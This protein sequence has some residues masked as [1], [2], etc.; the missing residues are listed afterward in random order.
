MQGNGLGLQ[1]WENQSADYKSYMPGTILSTLRYE[2]YDNHNSLRKWTLLL[3]LFYRWGSW[4]PERVSNLPGRGLWERVTQRLS[5]VS[6]LGSEGWGNEELSELRGQR[7]QKPWGRKVAGWRNRRRTRVT[8][9]QCS[10]GRDVQ[11]QSGEVDGG[12]WDENVGPI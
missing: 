5:L 3:S 4:G 8:G 11:I 9:A 2:P 7:V 1:R 12:H 6:E 10:R